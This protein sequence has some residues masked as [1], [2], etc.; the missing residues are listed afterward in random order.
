VAQKSFRS[1]FVNEE[2]NPECSAPKISWLLSWTAMV[3]FEWDWLRR[4]FWVKDEN[5]GEID[6]WPTKI[7]EAKRWEA[8]GQNI[9]FGD[10]YIFLSSFLSLGAC[11]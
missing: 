1:R 5:D 6:V 10:V 11:V 3:P 4:R 8:N 2:T 9:C 7:C